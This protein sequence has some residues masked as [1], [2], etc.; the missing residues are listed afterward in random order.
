MLKIIQD[1]SLLKVWHIEAGMNSSL[2][3]GGFG[4]VADD[5]D[6]LTNFSIIKN[7]KSDNNN[8]F[9]TRRVPLHLFTA[10]QTNP[11]FYREWWESRDGDKWGWDEKDKGN[12]TLK[13]E[14]IANIIQKYED[15][16][17][18]RIVCTISLS[19]QGFSA[20]NFSSNVIGNYL[21]KIGKLA[22]N[23]PNRN[24]KDYFLRFWVTK[25]V[26]NNNQSGKKGVC[27]I[28]GESEDT[29]LELVPENLRKDFSTAYSSYSV[30]KRLENVGLTR[31]YEQ[32]SYVNDKY[33]LK[34]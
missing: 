10:L 4:T 20:N 29:E 14:L 21:R 12:G 15:M 13:S 30:Y 2:P 28:T 22:K 33:L 17:E 18:Y 5:W 23:D 27:L 26:F 9:G 25:E 3:F 16:D 8:R 7:M 24:P 34:K 1:V 32:R 19:F 11:I 6:S 31:M